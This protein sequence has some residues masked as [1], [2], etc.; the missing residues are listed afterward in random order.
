MVDTRQAKERGSG[1]DFL[2]ASFHDWWGWWLFKSSPYALAAV[3][4]ITSPP[5][6]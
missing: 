2:P 3:I 5:H 1:G 4:W 6:R